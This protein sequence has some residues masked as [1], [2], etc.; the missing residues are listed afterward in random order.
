MKEKQHDGLE[1]CFIWNKITPTIS[2]IV[3]NNEDPIFSTTIAA[4]NSSTY[5]DIDSISRFQA[6]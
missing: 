4:P 3:I 1:T 6:L 2:G 5:I